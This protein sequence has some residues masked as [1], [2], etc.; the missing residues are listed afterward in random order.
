[1]NKKNKTTKTTDFQTY[2]NIKLKDKE[3]KKHYDEYGKQLEIAY[4]I[5]KLRK[6]AK[7]S[8]LEL[9]KKIHTTQSNVARIESGQQN[10]TIDILNKVAVAFNKNLRVSI[11]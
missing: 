6:K 4:Q 11:S 2:L 9:A 7:M 10:F 3:F 5:V 1:M 8:Q